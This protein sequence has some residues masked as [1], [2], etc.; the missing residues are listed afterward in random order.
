[1]NS[2]K[3]QVA[4]VEALVKQ[5][6]GFSA[7]LEY[8][9]IHKRWVEEY[10]KTNSTQEAARLYAERCQSMGRSMAAEFEARHSAMTNAGAEAYANN[11]N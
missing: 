9:F 8:N 11:W 7:N 4:E 2:V 5:V 6:Y 1:M 3:E 10:L